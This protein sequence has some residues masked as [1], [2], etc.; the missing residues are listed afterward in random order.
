MRIF[1]V[2]KTAIFIT[3]EKINSDRAGSINASLSELWLRLPEVGGKYPH[4]CSTSLLYSVDIYSNRCRSS[5]ACILEDVPVRLFCLYWYSQCYTNLKM[6]NSCF[7]VC[8]KR[9]MS[10]SLNHGGQRHNEAFKTKAAFRNQSPNVV[11]KAGGVFSRQK[12]CTITHQR[13]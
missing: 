4:P 6:N 8:E 2:N 7:S 9:F 5:V 3:K 10:A 13:L 1:C 12:V 11:K